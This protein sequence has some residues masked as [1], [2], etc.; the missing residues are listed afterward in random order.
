MPKE[1]HDNLCRQF[2]VVNEKKEIRRLL[3]RI[4]KTISLVNWE[5]R[6]LDSLVSI[7]PCCGRSSSQNTA[8]SF[9]PTPAVSSGAK[10]RTGF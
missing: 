7:V 3:D 5:Y 8:V 9:V 4:V 10:N 1:M 2:S 6:G